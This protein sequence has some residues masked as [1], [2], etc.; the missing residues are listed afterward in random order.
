V[1]WG[2]EE[3]EIQELY[4]L[5][6]DSVGFAL[7]INDKGQVVP[8]SGSCENTPL[9]PLP[10]GPHAVLWQDGP[11]TDLGSLGGKL[12]NTA[13][14]IN[15]RGE[16]V[17]GSTLP[18]D[19]TLHTFLWTEA[20]GM[21]DLGTARAD[22]S[23]LPTAINNNG[24]VVGASCV[25]ADYISG[26]C[27]AYL[28]QDDVMTDLNALIPSDSPWHLLIAYGINDIGQIVGQAMQKSTGEVHAFLATPINSEV[29]REE[30]RATHA[31]RD[32]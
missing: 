25:T 30:H 29:D 5:P 20:K 13:A 2:P 4:P 31:G 14:A 28:W 11:V 22:V 8:S 9:V 3:G 32:Q 26:P 15:D 7:G 21:R 19:A 23:S 24:Q 12:V 17:G 27:R 10:V 1:I 18:D 6:G 16:V